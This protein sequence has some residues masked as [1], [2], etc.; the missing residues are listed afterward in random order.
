M[1]VRGKW[2]GKKFYFGLHYDLH[3][4]EKD[5]ELGTRCGK[6]ELIPMLKLMNPD[7]VQT[8]CKGHPGY[9]SWFSK[10]EYASIPSGLKKDALKQWR[11]ATRELGLPLHCHYSGVWDSAAGKKYPNW[12]V[13][14]SKEKGVKERANHIPPPIPSNVKMCPLGP[15]VEK[16]MIPQMHELIDRYGVDGFWIDGDLWAVEPC[17]CKRCRKSFAEKTG[18]TNPPAE[19]DDPNWGVW[20]NFTRENFEA[21]VTKYCNAVHQHNPDVLVCSNWLQTFL[22]PGEPTVP[23]DWISGD[24]KW[25]FGLDQSRCEARF[26]STRKKPWDIMLWSFYNSHAIG[27]PTSPWTSKSPQMLMQEAAILLSFGGGVQLYENPGGVRD[28]RLVGWR[29]KRLREVGQFVKKRR[30]ICQDTESIPQIAVL[31]SEHHLRNTAKV[32][33]LMFDINCAPVTGAVYSLLENH[34]GVDVLDEWALSPRLNEFPAVVAPECHAMSEDMVIALKD[35]VKKG[36]KLLLSGADV[37]DRFGAAFLGVTKGRLEKETVYHVPAAEGAV[38]L[39]SESWRLVKAKKARILGHIGKT[40][41]LDETL[42]FPAATINR[43]GKGKVVYIPANLF[44]DFDRNRFVLTREFL[45]EVTRQLVG[46]LPIMIKAPTCVDVA[47]RKKGKQTIIHLVNRLSGIPN[48]PNNG[49]IDEIPPIGPVK[50]MIK[51]SKKPQ[52]VTIPLGKKEV[53]W[54]YVKGTVTVTLPAV[55]IHEAIVID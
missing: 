45:G 24:N 41:L 31:H 6:K 33:N 18:I 5:R 1:S 38:P 11:V 27:D 50:V 54:R 26:L 15:Y 16:L 46:K 29:Q 9:T 7:F 25:V 8:D 14:G 44:R 48:Q 42:S 53:M 28:G 34:Y 36:G 47:L 23:T 40:P 3:A 35:Y 20:W 22:N 19:V 52:S 37:F 43:V 21:Y 30:K 4:N 49:A 10:V 51:R 39:Y 32:K 13:V 12:R 17:Y 2:H 55:H